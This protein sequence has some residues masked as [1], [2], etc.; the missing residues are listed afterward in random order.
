MSTEVS[1][2]V[3]AGNTSVLE[4]SGLKFTVTQAY[5]N[6]AT[7][8][9]TLT[10]AAGTNVP[11]ATWPMPLAYVAA[12]NGVYRGNIPA[13]VALVPGKIFAYVVSATQDGATARWEGKLLVE[14]RPPVVT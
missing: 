12:S 5:A 2:T 3:W 4:L 6:T 13:G 14:K 11:G 10:N 1:L 7:A 8:T 9:V